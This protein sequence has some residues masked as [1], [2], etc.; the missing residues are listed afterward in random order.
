MTIVFICVMFKNNKSQVILSKFD[1]SRSDLKQFMSFSIKIEVWDSLNRN[2]TD[3]VVIIFESKRVCFK[4]IKEY[5]RGRSFIG[6]SFS[7]LQFLIHT[8]LSLLTHLL[9]HCSGLD[10]SV[11]ERTATVLVIVD[12]NAH[13]VL[14]LKF[15]YW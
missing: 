12:F 10:T 7:Q 1:K 13:S 4:Y 2:M 15:T 11:S 14:N 9:L 3:Y 6:L 8:L 5:T